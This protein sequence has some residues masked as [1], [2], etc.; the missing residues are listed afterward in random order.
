M[1]VLLQYFAHITSLVEFDEVIGPCD[2]HA[3]IVIQLTHILHFKVVSE[4]LFDALYLLQIGSSNKNI[5]NVQR[6]EVYFFSDVLYK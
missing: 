6:Y 5:I 3:K 4:L 2:L 1:F